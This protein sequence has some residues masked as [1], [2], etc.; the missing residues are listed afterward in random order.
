MRPSKATLRFLPALVLVLLAA[1]PAYVGSLWTGV[2]S[3]ALASDAPAAK[4]DGTTAAPTAGQNATAGTT[5]TTPAAQ[6]PSAADAPTAQ[7]TADG[8]AANTDAGASA[9]T[10]S[11]FD[12]LTLTKAEI[13][14]LRQLAKRRDELDARAKTLDDRDALLKAT[15]QKIAEEVKQ[16]QQMKAEYEQAKTARDDAAEANMRRLVTVYESMK[17]EE[18]A[19]I[20]ETMEG[21]VL[22]D[23]VTRMGE[24]RLAPILA[25]MSPAKA[26]ALTIAMANR[27]TLLPPPP[28]QG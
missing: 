26:Q 6:T 12:P 3:L 28:P 8:A 2:A 13:D 20:F 14:V 22:L 1:L 9:A 21:A 17:P 16:M 10:E 4:P 24:R 7:A 15:E 23:V 19:R 25:Q 11:T 18:A 27:R 5:T